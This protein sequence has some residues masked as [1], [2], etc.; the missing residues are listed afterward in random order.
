[1][2][3]SDYA[4]LIS[5]SPWPY[6]ILTI[7]RWENPV[8]F[9]VGREQA[10]KTNLSGACQIL[11]FKILALDADGPGLLLQDYGMKAGKAGGYISFHRLKI[12]A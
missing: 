8:L 3:G 10:C 2:I 5:S 9:R 1:M 6:Q 11:W 7:I 4:A 12:L